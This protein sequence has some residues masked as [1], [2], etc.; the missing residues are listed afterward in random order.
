MGQESSTAFR[1]PLTIGPVLPVRDSLCA[2]TPSFWSVRRMPAP[3]S[4]YPALTPS[5]CH[6]AS[7]SRNHAARIVYVA[8]LTGGDQLQHMVIADQ[9]DPLRPFQAETVLSYYTSERSASILCRT[10]LPKSE[11]QRTRFRVKTVD[12]PESWNRSLPVTAAETFVALPLS[13][14]GPGRYEA[15]IAL[16]EDG[17]TLAENT[18]AILK[19]V[20]GPGSEVKIDHIKRAIT[21]DGKPYFPFALFQNGKMAMQEVAALGFNSIVAWKPRRGLSTA[22]LE[23]ADAAGLHVI[24]HPTNWS[25]TRLNWTS[26]AIRDQVAVLQTNVFPKMVD[27]VRAHRALL[28]YYSIDEPDFRNAHLKGEGEN[29]VDMLADAYSIFH[30]R[31]PYHP[32]YGLF[33]MALPTDAAWWK[34]YDFGG[35]DYYPSVGADYGLSSSPLLLAKGTADTVAVADSHR[36]PAWI[37]LNAETYSGSHRPL[38]VSEQRC[39]TY[40]SLIYGAKGLLYFVGPLQHVDTRKAFRELASEVA[41]LSPALLNRDPGQVVEVLPRDA[42]DP[43]G[44]PPIHAR[45]KRRPDGRVV[46]L[47]ANSQPVPVS[48]TYQL[49]GR[50]SAV[51]L[52]TVVPSRMFQGSFTEAMSGYDTRAYQI[53]E[54]AGSS[55]LP[56]SCRSAGPGWNAWFRCGQVTTARFLLMP[57]SDRSGLRRQNTDLAGHTPR[58]VTSFSIRAL[59]MPPPWTTGRITGRGCSPAVR[60]LGMRGRTGARCVMTPTRDGHVCG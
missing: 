46:L 20:P 57:W 24:E 32:V 1:R 19:R 21:V 42:R 12:G 11:Y 25:E 58:A 43:Y 6:C 41:V 55:P 17:V 36:V 35:V 53:E 7:R 39:Q 27:A 51:R 2:Q 45:F 44:Y 47:V 28:A 56:L 15:S 30:A 5:V 3:I 29:L 38:N 52:F 26:E 16:M 22:M 59:S 18:V 50:T 37:V 54:G 10:S 40:L 4:A 9:G 13:G 60:R 23:D 34:G 48:V 33:S 14:V 8:V 49:S 31:D